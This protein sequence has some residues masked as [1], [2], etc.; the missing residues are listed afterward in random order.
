[1]NGGYV[2][3]L[4]IRRTENIGDLAANPAEYLDFGDSVRVRDVTTVKRRPPKSPPA[5]LIVGGGVWRHDYRA[6]SKWPG[7]EGAVKV[8]WGVGV[9]F[10]RPGPSPRDSHTLRAEGWDLYGHRD[11]GLDGRFLPCPSCLHPVFDRDFGKPEHE[12]VYYGHHEKRPLSFVQGF[13][14]YLTNKGPSME[15]AVEFLASGEVIVTTSYHGA[16]WGALLGRRVAV[17]PRATKF[18]HLPKAPDLEQHRRLQHEF[19]G[20][21]MAL[22]EAR[23]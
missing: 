21:V 15:E 7:F 14:P 5:L 23:S 18:W 17:L 10:P 11:V 13:G 22:L 19:H 4:N 2:L 9:S 12:V 1:M 8:A 3:A 20:D 6:M 16:Y